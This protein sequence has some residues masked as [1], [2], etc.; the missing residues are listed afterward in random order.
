MRT[1]RCGIDTECIKQSRST[2]PSISPSGSVAINSLQSLRAT[3]PQCRRLP[4]PSVQQEVHKTS[5]TDHPSDSLSTDQAM[6]A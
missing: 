4:F 6:I 2:S 3:R 1:T 5:Q